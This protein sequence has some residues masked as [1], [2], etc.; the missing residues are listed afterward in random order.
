MRRE[1]IFLFVLL[2]AIINFCACAEEE[3]FTVTGCQLI[4]PK[5]PYQGAVF[6]QNYERITVLELS[7]LNG[8]KIED[9]KRVQLLGT[10]SDAFELNVSS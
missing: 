6:Y 10:G 9:S 7:L 4:N 1:K 3:F 8:N 2:I 5:I